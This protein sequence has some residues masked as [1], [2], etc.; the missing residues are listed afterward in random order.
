V[1]SLY[2][3]E[4]PISRMLRL[5]YSAAAGCILRGIVS[6]LACIDAIPHI[7]NGGLDADVMEKRGVGCN[8]TLDY[9]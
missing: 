8:F 9:V 4:K 2:D 1:R 5:Y 6:Q 7:E 3:V